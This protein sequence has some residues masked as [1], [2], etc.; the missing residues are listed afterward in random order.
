[1]LFE[2]I[3]EFEKYHPHNVWGMHEQKLHHLL[4][5]IFILSYCFNQLFCNLNLVSLLLKENLYYFLPTVPIPSCYF[6][7]H[8]FDAEGEP[9]LLYSHISRS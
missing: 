3:C 2:S 8:L 6:Q 7:P 4:P 1:M 5:T 9:L